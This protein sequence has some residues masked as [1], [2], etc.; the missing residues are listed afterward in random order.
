MNQL[1]NTKNPIFAQF[2]KIALDE[3][4]KSYDQIAIEIGYEKGN[5]VQM[6]V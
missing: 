2:L 3:R 4:G 6:L 1:M 5:A